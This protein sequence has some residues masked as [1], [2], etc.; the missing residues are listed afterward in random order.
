MENLDFLTDP[1]TPEQ[2]FDCYIHQAQRL[3]DSAIARHDRLI[4]LK[5]IYE[6]NSQNGSK[7]VTLKELRAK[8]HG[9]TNI[10]VLARLEGF[11]D[12]LERAFHVEPFP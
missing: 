5:Q 6:S 2:V 8:Y 11:I 4:L 10:L 1:K 9:L 7:L 3:M 12:E